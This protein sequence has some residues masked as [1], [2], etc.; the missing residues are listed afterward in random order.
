MGAMITQMP[1][2]GAETWWSTEPQQ[3]HSWEP[4]PAPLHAVERGHELVP[5]PVLEIARVLR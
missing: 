3:L 5:Q 4:L 1:P 2:T